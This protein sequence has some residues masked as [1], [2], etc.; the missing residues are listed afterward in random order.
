M[1]HPVV[2]SVVGRI[3]SRMSFR[4]NGKRIGFA[5]RWVGWTKFVTGKEMKHLI[6]VLSTLLLPGCDYDPHA[7]SYTTEKP[8][9]EDIEGEYDG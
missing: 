7:H 5:H 6:P 4:Q 9:V 8:S 2:N 3:D 1:R